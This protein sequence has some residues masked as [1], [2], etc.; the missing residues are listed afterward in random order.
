MLNPFHW[1]LP[2]KDFWKT[3][4]DASIGAEKLKLI[5]NCPASTLYNYCSPAVKLQQPILKDFDLT[6]DLLFEQLS[7]NPNIRF[8]LRFRENPGYFYSFNIG[9][10]GDYYFDLYSTKSIPLIDEPGSLP[11]TPVVGI[12]MTFRI[13]ANDTDFSIY[14]NGALVTTVKDGRLNLPGTLSFF[15]YVTQGDSAT[16][17]IK[18]LH[19]YQVP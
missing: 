12:P 10:S 7:V 18:N 14:E 5:I 3:T 16:I 17:S 19:I 6:F 4:V 8:N 13:M 11:F 1:L 15:Y 9:N 2:D